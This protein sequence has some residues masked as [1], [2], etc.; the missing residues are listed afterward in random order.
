MK[1]Y[2]EI[3][4]S[5]DAGNLILLRPL[6]NPFERLREYESF[7]STFLR[8]IS[9]VFKLVCPAEFLQNKKVKNGTFFSHNV[10]KIT[11][12]LFL[13]LFDMGFF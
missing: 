7:H 8:R 4:F 10:D 11:I 3:Y 1:Y 9:I 12:T 6:S 2:E 5:E 13:T